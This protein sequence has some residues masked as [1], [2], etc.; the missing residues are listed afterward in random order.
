MLTSSRTTNILLILVLSAGIAII[1]MLATGVRGG[2]LDPPGPP[3]ST[4]PQ[5][6]PR[7]P[8]PPVGWNGT[9]PIVIDQPGS[10]FLTRNLTT[11]GAGAIGISITAN[12]VSLDL[13]GFTLD[14]LDTSG[15]GILSLQTRVRVHGGS[16]R[17]FG[18]GMSLQGTQPIVEDVLVTN[19]GAVGVVIGSNGVVADCFVRGG[20]E[21]GVLLGSS[22][23]MRRCTIGGVPTGVELGVR[24]LVEDSVVF[25][26]GTTGARVLGD[27]AVVRDSTFLGGAQDVRVHTTGA[28]II[29]NVIRCATGIVNVFGTSY[30]APVNGVEHSNQPAYSAGFC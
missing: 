20:S 29:D 23:V 10:Y 18:I 12:E 16:V 1:A 14:G 11:G 30:W 4:L 2:P 25:D 21:F 6:E 5:V 8:I 27:D 26:S 7:S 9:F 22:S 17:R 24:S 15:V 3:G 19:F 28:V 13:N